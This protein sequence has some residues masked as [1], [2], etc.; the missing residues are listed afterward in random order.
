MEIILAVIF[1]MLFGFALNRAGATNP[2]VIINML[3]LTDTHLIKVILF[4]V[5]VSSALLFGGLAAGLIDAGNLD[6][7]TLYW[8]VPAGGILLGI[9]WA[10]AG[11]CPGT[12][13]AAAGEGRK[14]A[15]FFVIGGLVG[16]FLY[17]VMHIKFMDT[18]I[19]DELLG[20]KV[21]LA[22]TPHE[23][24]PAL[25]T[26]IPGI[27]IAGAVAVIFGIAAWKLPEK[28]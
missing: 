17:T 8:G 25:I 3:R 2:Q 7:K 28:I 5:A 16:A 6:V 14:D 20:G 26:G 27:V 22:L 13:V 21:S 23:S 12:G 19:M 10:L 11:Y 9:G 1:G 18:F 4:A 24:F 15:L